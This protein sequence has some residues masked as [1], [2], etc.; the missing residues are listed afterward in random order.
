VDFSTLLQITQK[1]EDELKSR[2]YKLGMKK[3]SVLILLETPRPVQYILGKSVLPQGEILEE[4]RVLVADQF[5][6]ANAA[7]ARPGATIDPV[8][9]TAGADGMVHLHSGII[10]SEAKFL[11]IDF[12]VDNFGPESQA[13]VDE[14]SSCTLEQ[15][16]GYCLTK[17]LAV[18]QQRC[19]ERIPRLLGVV[20]E[21]NDTA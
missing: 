6:V 1:G 13:F 17:I 9:A 8:P 3:R 4:I 7:L 14:I 21:I 19:P 2:T 12:C 10:M 15:E 11:L 20:K 5:I 18:T 16:L